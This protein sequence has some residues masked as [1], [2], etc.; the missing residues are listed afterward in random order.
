MTVIR[1]FSEW[2]TV[3]LIFNSLRKRLFACDNELVK[4]KWFSSDL[5]MTTL[6]VLLEEVKN[7]LR[8]SLFR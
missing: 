5:M 1:V 4:L 8:P 6:T 3:I 2:I 7:S